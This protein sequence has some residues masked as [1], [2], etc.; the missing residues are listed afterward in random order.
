M[1]K[2]YVANKGADFMGWA[3]AF[4]ISPI[5]ARIIR[6]RGL[7]LESQVRLFLNGE[8]GDCYSPWLL[9]DMEKAVKELEKIISEKKKIRVIGDYD[10]DGICSSYILTTGFRILGAEVDTAIPHRI[11]DGY[12]LNEN[13]IRECA[14]D[15]IDFIV[16]CDNGIAAASQIELATEMGIQVIV[17]DHHEVPYVEEAGLRREILPKALAVIDPKQEADDYPFPEICGGVVAYKLIQALAE[18]TGNP[19]LNEALE[20]LLEFAALATVC[21]VMELKEENRIIVK[22]GLKRMRRTKNLGL[23][24]LLEANGV[25]PESLSAYHLGFVIGPCLNAT[26]RLDTAVRALELLNSETKGQAMTAAIQLKE[27]N[28]NRKSL[29]LE[30]VEKA[31][32]Y[33]EDNGVDK[34]PVMIVYLPGVHE[35]LV[36]IIA[37]RIREKYQHPVFVLTDAEEGIKGSGRSIE[38]YHMYEEMTAVNQFFI[39]YGGHKMAAGLSM[40]KENL[41]PFRKALNENAKLTEDDLVSKVHIDMELPLGEV[42][43]ELVE[44]M[45]KLEPFG[46]ANSKP[47]FAQKDVTFTAGYFFGKTQTYARF[48]VKCADGTAR[49]LVYFGDLDRFREFMDGK[50]GAGSYDS[51]FERRE[52]FRMHI[53]YQVGLNTYQG[54]TSVQYFLHSFC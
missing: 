26:G 35:S 54:Q 6:N 1:E 31:I 16:T 50:Y 19:K 10:V 29:T 9:K 14:A 38:T 22:E 49:T 7:T 12:G 17:T 43:K 2:W 3:K 45:E 30:G 25:N 48:T 53:A 4:D 37:G 28:D 8:I 27:L 51:L 40:A 46:V 18:D 34:D 24:C 20:E 15:G 36:G 11:H 23:A 41:E 21:D 5:L 47:I 52:T 32:Q 44:D 42:S 33:I 39:K 13:L